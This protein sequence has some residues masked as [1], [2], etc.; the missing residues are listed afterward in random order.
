MCM[1]VLLEGIATSGQVSAN[2]PDQQVV[3]PLTVHSHVIAWVVTEVTPS[4]VM[5][6]CHH[7]KE[8]SA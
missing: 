5:N 7:L 2:C 4:Y 6:H 3:S 1:A 8:A